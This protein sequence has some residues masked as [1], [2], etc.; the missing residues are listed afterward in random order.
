MKT[1]ID[2]IVET[3][4]TKL[5]IKNK[6]LSR[7]YALLVLTKGE[8]ITLKDVHDAWAMSMNFRP[9]T[10]YCY[11]HNHKSIVPFDELAQDVQNKDKN[12]VRKLIEIAKEITCDNNTPSNSNDEITSYIGVDRGGEYVYYDII[13][14][15]TCADCS[16]FYDNRDYERFECSCKSCPKRSNT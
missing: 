6:E 13:D 1:Y 10:E 11:G 14:F 15:K 3:V 2:E 8:R 7:L 5:H 12:Y 16:D 9:T 4:S